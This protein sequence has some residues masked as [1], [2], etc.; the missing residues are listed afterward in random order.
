MALLEELGLWWL[1]RPWY[2]DEN[3]L[4]GVNCLL[5]IP[6]HG[7]G[8]PHPLWR[9]TLPG[10]KV[11]LWQISGNWDW[12]GPSEQP[13]IKNSLL[14]GFRWLSLHF[15]LWSANIEK[16][17]NLIFSSSALKRLLCTCPHF[18]SLVSFSC[19]WWWW[20]APMV[21]VVTLSQLTFKQVGS[22]AD[23]LATDFL[24]LTKRGAPLFWALGHFSS[25]SQTSG[26]ELK[27]NWRL[28]WFIDGWIF[29]NLTGSLPL[30]TSKIASFNSSAH[31]KRFP[32]RTP[33]PPNQT[34]GVLVH[35]NVAIKSTPKWQFWNA[36]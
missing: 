10:G 14:F 36:R 29:P 27:D 21:V 19:W 24:L 28:V 13:V 31:Y 17:S 1:L 30:T 6:Q 2:S 33:R 23:R 9:S 3:F 5:F 18:L 15:C 25:S 16:I 11:H 4:R 26:V 7:L 35:I 32:N 22:A 8:F 12:H 34:T 20:V